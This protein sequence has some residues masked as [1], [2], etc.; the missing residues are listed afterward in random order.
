MTLRGKRSAPSPSVLVVDADD[1]T[2]RSYRHSFALMGCE[3]VEA[4]DGRD[5]LAKAL[6]RPPTLVVTEMTLPFVDGYALCEILRR[7][8]ATANVPILV[9]T[10]ETLPAQVDRAHRA[11]ADIVLAKRTSI[12]NVVNE[13]RHLLDESTVQRDRGAAKTADA[14]MRCDEVGDG[15]PEQ[16]QKPRSTAFAR[17]TTAMPSISPPA[18]VCPSC[19]DPLTYEHS[20]IGGVTAQQ[21]EQWDH[22]SCP[23][24]CGRFEYRHR[25][26]K[27]RRVS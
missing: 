23:G 9:V 27:L 7:D 4:C 11:G 25:T 16:H 17:Q 22:Y 12:Q 21:S 18:L 24:S 15:R 8:R 5:A 3:V 26:R 1:A 19:D 14:T 2:R 20:H 13:I 10:S 6:P